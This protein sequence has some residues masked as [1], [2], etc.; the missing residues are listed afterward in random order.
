MQRFEQKTKS[1]VEVEKWLRKNRPMTANRN[2]KPK[3]DFKGE[4]ARKQAE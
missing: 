3:D 1:K 2:I 4:E